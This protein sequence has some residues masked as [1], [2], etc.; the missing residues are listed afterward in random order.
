MQADFSTVFLQAKANNQDA[1]AAIVDYFMRNV[2]SQLKNLRINPE[3]Y[4]QKYN[5]C[6]EIIITNLN[7]FYESKRFLEITLK[8]IKEII[9]LN[10]KP[11]SFTSGDIVKESES[12]IRARIINDDIEQFD[13]PV[14]Y[15][16][17]ARLYYINGI[18]P[19]DLAIMYKCTVTIIYKRLKSVANL[20][21]M[22]EIA[23]L[24]SQDK[25][26]K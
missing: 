21:F 26:Y 9:Y 10:K 11:A 19:E 17:C 18:S 23:S 16:E 13:I 8:N 7:R 20:I 1:I 6:L 22:N 5:A 14:V 15:K 25:I 24:V 2:E 4:Y 3:D 12:Y